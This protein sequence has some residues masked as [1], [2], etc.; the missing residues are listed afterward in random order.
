MSTVYS[1]QTIMISK[2]EMNTRMKMLLAF[3]VC[4]LAYA[5]CSLYFSI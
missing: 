4:Y 5:F 1:P 2:K 3:A